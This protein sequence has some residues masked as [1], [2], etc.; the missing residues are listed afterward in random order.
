M[1]FFRSICVLAVIALSALSGCNEHPAVSPAE[2]T[3]PESPLNRGGGTA[4][5]WSEPIEFTLTPED[6]PNITTVI[7]GSGWIRRTARVTVTANGTLKLSLTE[8]SR[9]TAAGLDGSQYVF[10]YASALRN[11]EP[12]FETFP[13]TLDIIDHFNLNGRN[14]A[15]HV[16]SW[17]KGT[18]RLLDEETFEPLGTIRV[19]GE[20]ACDP[21]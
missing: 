17:F 7:T 19:H 14:G 21:I 11:I 9:G 13:I 6:C 8:T 3:N 5:S 16:S 12:D 20:P 4:F 18:F 1:K 10:N 2:G 15:P